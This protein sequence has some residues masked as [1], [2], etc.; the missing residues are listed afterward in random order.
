MNLGTFIGFVTAFVAFTVTLL[1][2]FKNLSVILDAH[3][4][5]IVIGGTVSVALICFPIDR[6]ANLLKVFMRRLFGKN[7]RDFAFLIQ[8]IVILSEAHR[9]GVRQFEQAIP[10]VKD[11]FLRD[12]ANVLF[13]I[14]A[15]VSSEELRDLLDTRVATHFKLYT[16]EAKVFKTMGKFPP[17]FGL[18]GTTIGMIALLQSLGNADAK[19]MI[20]PAMSVALVA[21]LYGLVLT[22]FVFA[23]IAENL[24]EQTQEDLMA[25]SIVVEGIMLILADKPTKYIE[26]KVKSFLL[27]KDRGPNT[28][29]KSSAGGSSTSTPTKLAG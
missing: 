7:K 19:N 5:M 2:S 8:E 21:T 20:G 22:N 27:P 11:P 17:A 12:A 23:P 10:S 18:M 4:A 14:K 16:N 15:E 26:E 13:W 24:S 3:A 28:G 6:I 29:G 9:K 25:R 1:M